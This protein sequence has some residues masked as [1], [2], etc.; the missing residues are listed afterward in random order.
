MLPLALVVDDEPDI[1]ELL[2]LTLQRMGVD[3]HSAANLTEAKRFL[4]NNRYDFCLTDLRLPDGDGLQLVEYIQNGVHRDVPIA[5]IT[6][7]GNMDTAIKALKLGAFDFVSKPVD[8]E[9]LRTLVQL[10]LRLNQNRHR[11]QDKNADQLLLGDA[12]NIRMLREQI[13]KVAR[14][15]APVYISGE[16]GS[17]KELA[18]RAIHAQGAR[19][20][21][22]FVPI[23]CGAIPAELM[24]SEFFG[25]K[26]AVSPAPTRI[27]RGYCKALRGAPCFW[28]KSPISRWICR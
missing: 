11:P 15:D 13:A 3:C 28:T 25:H 24:E 22:P 6:A 9:R 5:V 14:S 12:D 21:K 7:H 10:A 19:A 26:R 17:G 1:C 18:A 27:I 16:S 4:V 2:S 8:L 23:N 20:D